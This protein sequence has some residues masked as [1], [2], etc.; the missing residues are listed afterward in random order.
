M[1]EKL[2][3][4]LWAV[5]CD[6]LTEELHL[7]G[8]MLAGC[9]IIVMK[10]CLMNKWKALSHTRIMLSSFIYFALRYSRTKYAWLWCTCAC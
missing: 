4:E 8:W 7:N 10:I 3:F 9:K 6:S 1:D 2:C 5:F